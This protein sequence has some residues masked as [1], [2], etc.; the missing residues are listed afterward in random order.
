MRRTLAYA[1]AALIITPSAQAQT[2][3]ELQPHQRRGLPSLY[4]IDLGK[5]WAN[6]TEFQSTKID[7]SG[8]ARANKGCGSDTY[9]TVTLDFDNA[10]AYSDL[11]TALTKFDKQAMSTKVRQ[12]FYPNGEVYELSPPVRGAFANTEAFA[13]AY[14]V[15]FSDGRRYR[16]RHYTTF[17]SGYYVHF[18]TYN[19]TKDD[20]RAAPCF[21]QLFETI[22]FRKVKAK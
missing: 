9:F 11:E 16:M 1:L 12:M 15:T 13:S 5:T 21:K 3:R 7:L 22:T 18:N 2:A 4:S 20:L 17:A 10:L 6:I 8:K 19:L 14:R